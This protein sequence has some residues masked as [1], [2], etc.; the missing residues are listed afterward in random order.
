[1][2]GGNLM[3]TSRYCSWRLIALVSLLLV[4]GG[5]VRE[6]KIDGKQV[7][8]YEYWV[9]LTTL[10]LGL[11]AIPAGWFLR[12]KNGRFGWGLLILGPVAAIFFAPSL[13]RDRVTVG[14]DGFHV[15]TGIWGLTAVHEVVFADITQ[16]RITAEKVSTRRGQKTNYFMNCDAKSGGSSKVPI[17]NAVTEEAADAILQQAT[18]HDIPILD[19]RNGL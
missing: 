15:R 17:N 19:H 9:P 7:Y 11:A 8:Q 16:I 3:A 14:P 4:V 12:Q 5:C 1:M 2:N 13:F 10:V 6:S 18:D